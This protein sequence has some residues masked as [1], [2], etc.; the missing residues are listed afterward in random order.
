M[1]EKDPPELVLLNFVGNIM[2]LAFL[3][4][5]L[6][7]VA[8]GLEALIIYTIEG[9]GAT[10][11]RGRITLVTLLTVTAIGSFIIAKYGKDINYI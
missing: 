4:L 7:W 11:H 6:W 5:G 10:P 1:K 9:F 3:C 2:L 8:M